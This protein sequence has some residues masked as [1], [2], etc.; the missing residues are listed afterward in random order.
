MI[1][2]S[3]MER[4]TLSRTEKLSESGFTGL[5]DWER[6]ELSLQTIN[7]YTLVTNEGER[8]CSEFNL[9]HL[10]RKWT[11]PEMKPY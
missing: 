2:E 3:A 8:D 7:H 9:I 4:V 10:S 6:I 5:G 1:G 11:L